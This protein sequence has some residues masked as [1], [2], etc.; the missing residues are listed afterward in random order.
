MLV[1]FVYQVDYYIIIICKKQR[2]QILIGRLRKDLTI[3]L[4]SIHQARSHRCVP[5]ISPGEQTRLSYS[6]KSCSQWSF[7]PNQKERHSK[8]ASTRPN[9]TEP[10]K[11]NAIPISHSYKNPRMLLTHIPK[12]KYP[13]ASAAGRDS[14]TSY[15]ESQ[16]SH[17]PAQSD[18]PQSR[19]RRAG[20]RRRRRRMRL[21]LPQKP[22]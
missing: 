14:V 8:V 16:R 21:F 9:A 20:R 3:I 1:V 22:Y 12:N 13:N 2:E 19:R 17:T 15:P 7:L 11:S 6:N 5:Y 18:L 10:S 4:H